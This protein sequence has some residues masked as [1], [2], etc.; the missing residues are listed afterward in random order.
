MQG[1]REYVIQFAG[2]GLGKHDYEF[3]VK[4]S[5]FDDL[6]YSEIKQGSIAVKMELLKQS[7]MMVLEFSIGGTVKAECDLCTGEFDLPIEG[8]YR[9][10][11]K[12]GGHETGD[13]DDDIITIAANEHELDIS[14]YIYE[15]II[16]SLPVKR[17][18]PPDKKGK[19]TCDKEVLEK[20][21]NF[22]IEDEKSEEEEETDPR[23]NGLKNIKLN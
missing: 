21:G 18:H 3:E 7:Q 4:D 9:L 12:V 5:F 14:Q 13:E 15:Y 19:S 6:D 8:N 16:L 10:I 23:W 11:V 2:L 22:L 17:V 20:L 1:R